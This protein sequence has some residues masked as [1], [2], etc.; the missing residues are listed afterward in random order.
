MFDQERRKLLRFLYNRSV[1]PQ[2]IPLSISTD[3]SS[4][5][6]TG[7]FRSSTTASGSIKSSP[8]QYS[9]RQARYITL[10]TI[11]SESDANLLPAC[12][13]IQVS[14]ES[15]IYYQL[16]NIKQSISQ[17]FA[18]L[19]HDHQVLVISSNDE[20]SAT[21]INSCWLA[22]SGDTKEI[23]PPKQ[24]KYNLKNVSFYKRPG[25]MINPKD[26]PTIK[27]LKIKDKQT[28][29]YM[30]INP[31]TQQHLKDL[32]L[33]Y[34]NTIPAASFNFLQVSGLQ[35]IQD[36]A[37]IAITLQLILEGKILPYLPQGYFNHSL[38]LDPKDLYKKF[39][40]SKSCHNDFVD[41]IVFLQ[42][43]DA[44]EEDIDN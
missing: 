19:Q 36:H 6:E 16:Q 7:T 5:Y 15:E 38:L 32:N 2:D 25:K 13:E 3:L 21:L 17:K 27:K 10:N 39:R 20:L 18:K 41:A 22:W 31:H 37:K 43:E 1:D 14:S 35:N 28:G 40:H 30:P 33:P 34:V 29:K 4:G 26:L 12:S 8:F 24:K 9:S 44:S 23:L 11:H 42:N